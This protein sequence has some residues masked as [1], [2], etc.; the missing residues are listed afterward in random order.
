MSSAKLDNYERI[1]L[2]MDI[3]RTYTDVNRNRINLT[4]PACLKQTMMRITVITR[5]YPLIIAE[6][7][8]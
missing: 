3:Q 1:P 4:V 7:A 2:N 6:E 5:G 8:V